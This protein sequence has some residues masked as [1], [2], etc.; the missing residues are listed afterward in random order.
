MIVGY[1]PFRGSNDREIIKNVAK[2][3]LEFPGEEWAGASTEVKDLIKKMIVMDPTQRLTA[4][5]V[6]DHAWFGSR[7]GRRLTMKS[8]SIA[9]PVNRSFLKDYSNFSRFKKVVYE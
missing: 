2:G 8:M 1:P 7:K 4:D 9:D 5:Q 3:V 6:M